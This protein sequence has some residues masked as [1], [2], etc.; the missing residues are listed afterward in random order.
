MVMVGVFVSS[1]QADSQ[2]KSFGLVWGLA[3]VWHLVC[4]YRVNRV[5]SCNG[6]AMMTSTINIGS[7]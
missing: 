3:A 7:L 5:N 4:I 2:P 1:L 6:L